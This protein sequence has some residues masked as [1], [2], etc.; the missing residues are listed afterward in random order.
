MA[1]ERAIIARC[2]RNGVTSWQNVALQ[3]GMSVDACRK[4]FDMH[5]LPVRVWPHPCAPV[6][7]PV[8]AEVV[9]EADVH[10][11]AYKGPGMRVEIAILL[12]RHGSLSVSAIAGRLN[13]TCN[14]VRMRLSRMQKDGWVENDSLG[15]R[16]GTYE[17]T[18]SLTAL[19]VQVAVT[20]CADESR[21]A[22]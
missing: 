21:G 18:W 6:A 14:S 7:A 20:R 15:R 9:D 8:A 3:L 2:T 4:R 19:G 12:K 5:Y 22:A 13:R 10:S 16:N 17:W 1:D 11:M